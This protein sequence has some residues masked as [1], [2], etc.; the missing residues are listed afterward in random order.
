MLRFGIL[1]FAMVLLTHYGAAPLAELSPNPPGAVR[2]W[3][4]ILRGFE[5]VFLFGAILALLDVIHRAGVLRIP[6][7][8]RFLCFGSCAW[9]MLEE[10]ET[11]VCRLAIGVN[12][13]T[14]SLVWSGLCDSCTGLPI[15]VAT[16]CLVAWIIVRRP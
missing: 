13:K 4:Y 11:A 3:F 2:A 12:D 5:G 14:P 8:A 6:A 10:G 7:Y 16:L 9:G 15:Y 1:L